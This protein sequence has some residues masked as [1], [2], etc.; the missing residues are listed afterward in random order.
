[1]SKRGENIY[2]RK[3]NR[4]EARYV[5]GH[6]A[7]GR[8]QYGYC[9]GKTYREAKEKQQKARLEARAHP[10]DKGTKPKNFGAYCDDWL[11]FNRSKIK[12]STY[13][14]YENTLIQL[15]KLFG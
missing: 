8:I 10:A 12:E 15:S 13:V 2:K 7:E 14:K 6:D 3:D 1:M 9:Y 11:K 4:W 5:K